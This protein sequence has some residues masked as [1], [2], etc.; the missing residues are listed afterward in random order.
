MHQKYRVFLQDA[1][2]NSR[3]GNVQIE[4]GGSAIKDSDEKN[5]RF[6][7][8][9]NVRFEKREV[10]RQKHGGD[11]RRDKQSTQYCPEHDGSNR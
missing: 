5:T 9:I 8:R 2:I 4:D 1:V 11:S 10:E 7:Y 3:I 6:G